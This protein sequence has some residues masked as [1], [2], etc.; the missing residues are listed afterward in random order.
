M[1]RQKMRPHEESLFYTVNT[2]DVM[3]NEPGTPTRLD[4]AHHS[5]PGSPT[6]HQVRPVYGSQLTG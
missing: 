4:H 3:A 6:H 2:S 5:E 1:R